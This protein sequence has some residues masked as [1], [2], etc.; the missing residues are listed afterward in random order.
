[1]QA[2]PSAATQTRS[3]SERAR[4]RRR[5]IPK[6]QANRPA[7]GSTDWANHRR[8]LPRDE[9]C[10]VAMKA[11]DGAPIAALNSLNVDDQF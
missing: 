8:G 7:G 9:D 1:M 11:G 6:G 2:P 5:L 10:S 3:Q 4:H